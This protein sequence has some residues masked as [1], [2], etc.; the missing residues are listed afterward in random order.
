MLLGGG[1]G[2]IASGL[3][4]G[5]KMWSMVR[6]SPM[7]RAGGACGPAANLESSD[8]RQGWTEE[9]LWVSESF[10]LGHLPSRG[11]SLCSTPQRLF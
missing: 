1:G 2:K 3:E 7:H 6:P 8:W 5:L 4:K 9:L 11:E 10:G